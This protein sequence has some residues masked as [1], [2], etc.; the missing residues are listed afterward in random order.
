VADAARDS[1][2]AFLQMQLHGSR[3]RREPVGRKSNGRRLAVSATS[4]NAGLS[5]GG[6]E[7]CG[8]DV[9]AAE[10]PRI[11]T[12]AASSRAYHRAVRAQT[13]TTAGTR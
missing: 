12:G 3:L 10:K 4:F 5:V 7:G 13:S 6:S 9:G 11:P 1:A 8:A 2:L